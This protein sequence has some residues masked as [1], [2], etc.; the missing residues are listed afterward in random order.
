VSVYQG[1]TTIEKHVDRVKRINNERQAIFL[2]AQ[3]VKSD[4]E[5]VLVGLTP[6]RGGAPGQQ[7]DVERWRTCSLPSTRCP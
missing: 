3:F 5:R 1:E 4:K 6:E 2:A 7:G